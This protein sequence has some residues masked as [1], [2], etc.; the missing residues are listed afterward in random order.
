MLSFVNMCKLVSV[1]AFWYDA[2]SAMR[3]SIAIVDAALNS[4]DPETSTSRFRSQFRSCDGTG[5][6]ANM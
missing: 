4:G 5:A 2:S 3:A 1:K 6:E